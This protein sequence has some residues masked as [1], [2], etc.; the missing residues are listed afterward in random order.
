[1]FLARFMIDTTSLQDVALTSRMFPGIA[2]AAIR[3]AANVTAAAANYSRY[4]PV[5]GLCVS[6][7]VCTR[8]I[9]RRQHAAQDDIDDVLP[10]FRMHPSRHCTGRTQLQQHRRIDRYRCSAA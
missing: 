4:I 10:V 7:A 5:K 2:D 1:M 8:R 9:R 3:A 6:P